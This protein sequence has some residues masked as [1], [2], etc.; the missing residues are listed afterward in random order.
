[1]NEAQEPPH[2]IT[3]FAIEVRPSS[4]DAGAEVTLVGEVWCTPPLDLEGHPV[5]IRGGEGALLASTEIVA[6]DGV[7]NRSGELVLKAPAATGHCVWTAVLT[8]GTA[9]GVGFDEAS[10]PIAFD[11][12]PHGTSVVVWDVPATIVA[13][14]RFGIKVGVKCSSECTPAGWQI[15]IVDHAGNPLAVATP[16]KTPWPGTAALYF[17]DV[18]LTAAGTEGLHRWTARATASDAELPHEGSEAGF[19]VRFVPSPEFLVRVEVV[20]KESR[21]PVR[22]AKVVVHP[23]RVFTDDRGVAEVRVP[24]G[25]YTIFVSG[26]K[27]IPFRTVGAVDADTTIVAELALDVG[28]SDADIW[29]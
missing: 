29:S 18:E 7:V 17:A 5:L 20:D 8:A 15:E 3:S 27:H 22:S 4:V 11:V 2:E 24:K 14:E 1:M 13:G 9:D 12:V 21:A 6:F 23:Y 16:G 26:R 25:E 28:L 10:A 19:S